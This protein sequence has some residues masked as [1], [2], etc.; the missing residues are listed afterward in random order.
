MTT[1]GVPFPYM[2]WARTHLLAFGPHSL[3][4]SGRPRPDAHAVE[5][6]LDPFL[7][8]GDHPEAALVKAIAARHGWRPDGVLLALGTSHA[9]F[10]AC[11]ALAAGA[12]IASETPTYDVFIRTAPAIG[13]TCTTFARDPSRGFR[14][15]G[16]SLERAVTDDTAL[17]AV[18]DLHNPSGAPLHPE[19]LDRLVGL[20]KAHD[21]YLLVDEVYLDLDPD[22]RPSAVHLG[23]RV[24]STNS[25]TKAHGLG[26]LRV[27]W[28]LGAPEVIERIRVFND[29]VCPALP[30]LTMKQALAALPGADA[31]LARTRTLAAAATDQVDA[32]VAAREDATWQKPHAGFTGLLHLGRPGTPLD[33]DRVATLALEEGVR[34]VPGRFFGVPEALRVSYL[35]GPDDLDRALAALG[36]ALDRASP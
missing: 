11:H 35:L 21:A 25:L 10:V 18:T 34:V 23:D 22:D 12:S 19:D 4:M 30:A 13:S 36:R 15:D 2:R 6:L 20:T 24:L 3:G 29:L 26:D 31:R 27:G 33:G 1:D 14:I 28:I 32:W 7:E 5:G 17:I 8:G 9:N 16:A